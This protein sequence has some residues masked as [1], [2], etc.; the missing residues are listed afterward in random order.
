MADE[1]GGLGDGY[2][3]NTITGYVEYIYWVVVTEDM[4]GEA[5]KRDGDVLLIG[6]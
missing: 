5:V 4:N 6:E 3:P 1:N 2:C